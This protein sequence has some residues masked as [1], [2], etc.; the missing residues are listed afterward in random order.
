MP[1]FATPAPAAAATSAAAVEMLN[2]LPPS[3]PVP[4]VSTRSSRFGRTAITCARI[5]SA[6]P[7]ISAGGLALQP[8]RDEE[9]ADL[10]RRRL[11]GHDRAH[12][13]A[14]LRRGSGPGRRA[15]VR[16]RPGSCRSEEVL[17]DVAAE[18]G[19]H[20]LGVELYAVDGER[21]VPHGHHLAVGRG[22]RDLED[23]GHATSPRASGSGR[24]GSPRAGRRRCRGRRA[25][26]IVALPWTSSRAWPTVPPCSC[27][28]AWWPRQTPSVGTRP[29]QALE[30]R[31]RR[32]CVLGPAGAG[33]DDEM[34]R[35]E[36]LRLVRRDRVVAADDHVGAELAEQVRRGCR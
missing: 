15:A 12:H 8:Q 16:A 30:D 33:G 34:R 25:R 26:P 6:A 18:R 36:L 28:S 32:A 21:P 35:R 4:A 27:T 3:P 14:R 13:V 24:R 2:V 5:A 17:R 29:A 23:V 22:R 9:A 19:Q 20:R 11:A 1:C 10:R 31:E 7:A